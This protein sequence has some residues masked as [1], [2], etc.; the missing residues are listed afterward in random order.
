M[1]LPEKREVDKGRAR[2]PGGFT[3]IELA[4][5]LAIFGLLTSTLYLALGGALDGVGR[6]RQAQEPYQRGRVA[7]SFLAGSLRSAAP[8]SG[9]PGDGFVAVDSARSGVPRDELTFVALAPARAG[10][11]RMQLHLA[12]TDSGGSPALRLEVREFGVAG[13]SL[14]PFVGYTLSDGVA[15]LEIEYLAAPAES[16]TLWMERWD[17]SIR[18][19][20]AVRITFLPAEVADPAYRTPLLIQIPAGRIL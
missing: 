10:A 12:V 2:T 3:L 9:L 1:S 4:V 14:P 15:G 19:P 5:A 7:R 6:I 11:G 17:S 18:L 16:R 13:D 20:Y 8:F